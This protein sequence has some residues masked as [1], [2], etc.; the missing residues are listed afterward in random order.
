MPLED[1]IDAVANGAEI[2]W[3]AAE[4]AVRGT[5][6]A[7]ALNDLKILSRLRQLHTSDTPS[8]LSPSSVGAGAASPLT[9]PEAIGLRRWG[10][11]QVHDRVGAGASCVVYRARDPELDRDVA[12]KLLRSAEGTPRLEEGRR[13]ARVRHPNVVVVHGADTAV[14]STGI[15]MEFIDGDTLHDV[16]RERGPFGAHEAA[17]IG[18]DICRALAAVHGAGLLHRDLTAKNVMRERGGRIVLMDF[19]IGISVAPTGQRGNNSVAGTPLYTAPEVLRGEPPTV[20]AEIYSLGVLLW[21]LM[22][23]SYPHHATSLPELTEAASEPVALRNARADLPEEF[24]RVVERALAPC[25]AERYPNVGAME[26]ALSQFLSPGSDPGRPDRPMGAAADAASRVVRAVVALLLISGAVPLVWLL[27]TSVPRSVSR[28]TLS[29]PETDAFENDGGFAVSPNGRTLVY[30]AWHNGTRQLFRRTLDQVEA[31]PIAS[32]EEASFPFFSPNGQWIGFFAGDALLKKVA[33]QGG[34]TMTI[35]PAGYR[36]GASWGPNGVIVFASFSSPDLMQVADT[37]GT[38]RPLTAMATQKGQRA[39]WPELTPDGRAVLYTILSGSLDT[40]RIVV[41]SIDTGTE[42]DLVQGTNPR[43][44]PTGHLVFARAGDLW[45]VPFDRQRLVVTDSPAKVLEGVEVLT[46]GL[47]LFSVAR[48]GS[49]VHATPG[50]AI[51]VTRDRTGRADVLLDVPHGYYGV[52]QPSPDGH[53]LAMAFSGRVGENPAIWIY[54]LERRLMRRL[55]SE[56]SFDTDPLWTP[57]GQRVVFGSDRVGGVHHLFWIAAGGSGVAEPLTSGPYRQRPASWTP[58]GRVLAFVEGPVQGP[59]SGI[60]TLGVNPAHNP[61][62]FVDTLNSVWAAK[63]SPDARWLAYDSSESGR[64]EVYVRPFPT[65][66]GQWQV[67]PQGGIFPQ[68]SPDGRELFYLNL[69]HEMM[70][71]KVTLEPTF[72]A[73]TPRALFNASR[74]PGSGTGQ[75]FY[76]VM[77]DGQH[78]VMLQP[79]DAPRQLQVTL[80]WLE[81]LKAHVR[82]Q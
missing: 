60:W 28:F 20:Q 79:V 51:V 82:A 1:V 68:W 29:L 23:G 19:G 73:A 22:T 30:V 80:N 54:D 58:D 41:R 50:T 65:A 62:P 55:T 70:A 52:P 48:D 24:A 40:A 78:F 63:F 26:R 21:Y 53:R 43:L 44:T 67:S 17:V 12:L 61:E 2:D 25:A 77:P 11:L 45:A 16:V 9:L 47:A 6:A 59:H 34:P 32:T 31:V 7:Q 8:E 33:L 14:D 69:E 10:K 42:R 66:G 35:C 37:G 64:R 57:D 74:R 4:A 39:S 15:W 3:A 18:R 81:D 46:G 76:S 36:K 5:P 27:A 13:L 75:A 56:G 38:P 71:V 49:L 72:Q